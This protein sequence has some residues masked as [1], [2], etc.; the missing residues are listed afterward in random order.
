[1][2]YTEKDHTFMICAYKENP[3]LEQCVLSVLNQ[4][5]L[6]NVKISTSTPN[7][8]IKALA[9]KYKLPLVVNK[10]IGDVVNNWNFAYSQAETEL[11]TLCHQDDYYDAHYLENILCSINATKKPL[12][13]CT[14]YYEDR[15]SVH[16]K[17]NLLIKIKRF[18]IFPLRF[19]VLRNK[20]IIKRLALAFGCPVCCPSVT[21]VRSNLP[22]TIFQ[23][24]YGSNYDWQAWEMLSK[25]DGS[26]IYITKA[27]T[28]HRIH[29]GSITS[30][31]LLENKRGQEDYD[32]F[33]KFWP[34]LIAKVLAKAYSF[35]EKSNNL[36]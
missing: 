5:I 10:G 9:K 34:K 26:F 2:Q 7:Q 1:M 31:M 22:G 20:K 30:Q 28:F 3:Y 8:Y 35:S 29:E 18:L 33:C 19:S 21:Y 27:L 24:G 23:S 36:K 17:S 12:I 25:L 11:V 14:N 32:M 13:A 4:T 16:I 15:N 6:G